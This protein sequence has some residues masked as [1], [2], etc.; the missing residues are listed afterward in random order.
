M[1]RIEINTNGVTPLAVTPAGAAG[2][3]TGSERAKLQNSD[4]NLF[5]PGSDPVQKSL[6]GYVT[7]FNMR[8]ATTAEQGIMSRAAMQNLTD[9]I[10]SNAAQTTQIAALQAQL[11]I[12]NDTVSTVLGGE[13]ALGNTGDQGI[14][15]VT[16]NHASNLYQIA[17]QVTFRNSHASQNGY[18][19]FR[20]VQQANGAIL[21]SGNVFI[22]FGGRASVGFTGFTTGPLP[23]GS[24]IQL[25]CR[26][27]ITGGV[28]LV[29]PINGNAEMYA[30]QL[31]GTYLR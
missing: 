28:I 31:N 24:P 14:L 29:A 30:T 12:I 15:T 4:I 11:A 3:V 23:T 2:S 27:S 18:G 5:Y 8:E 22:P 6:V 26:A 7:T 21:A 1:A 25:Q 10:S 9:V 20:L 19:Y 17:G 16:T 13:I